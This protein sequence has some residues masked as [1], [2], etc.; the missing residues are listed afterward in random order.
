MQTPAPKVA[1]SET[2]ALLTQF[3]RELASKAGV[4]SDEADVF[5]KKLRWYQNKA[6][7]ICILKRGADRT[8]L[9]TI[10]PKSGDW[11]HLYPSWEAA[12]TVLAEKK[13]AENVSR[14]THDDISTGNVPVLAESEKE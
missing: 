1:N 2:D 8:L 13:A 14:R 5:A 3:A 11:T 10:S 7:A 6:G 9:A 12:L 4:S